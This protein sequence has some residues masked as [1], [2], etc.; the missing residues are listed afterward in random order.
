MISPLAPPVTNRTADSTSDLHI[1]I[2]LPVLSSGAG[3]YQSRNKVRFCMSLRKVEKILLD[4][5]FSFVKVR[6]VLQP[7]ENKLHHVIWKKECDGAAIFAKGNMVRIYSL[8]EK[9]QQAEY[10]SDEFNLEPLKK[11]EF[12]EYQ[13]I[14]ESLD[15]SFEPPLTKTLHLQFA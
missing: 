2:Y 8:G 7:L 1:S 14:K 4:K 15:Q 6:Q 9:I 11:V 10:V 13:K 3:S 5:G 12:S